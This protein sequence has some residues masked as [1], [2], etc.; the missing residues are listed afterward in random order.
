MSNRHL[1]LKNKNTN[2]NEKISLTNP[3]EKDSSDKESLYSFT[4][5]VYTDIDESMSEYIP[6]NKSE[7][8]FSEEECLQKNN[9]SQ[10][11]KNNSEENYAFDL[12]KNINRFEENFET[13]ENEVNKQDFEE[14]G[15]E[16]NI[17]V[18]GTNGSFNKKKYCPYCYNSYSKLS[19]H[20]KSAHSDEKEVYSIMNSHSSEEKKL[21]EK[22]LYKLKNLGNHIHNIKVLRE[23]RGSLVVVYRPPENA[24]VDPYK[25]LPCSSCY[26]YFMGHDIKIHREYYRLPNS[27]QQIAKLS[28][29]FLS[30]EEGK[31][32]QNSGKNLEDIEV[33]LDIGKFSFLY[34][35]HFYLKKYVSLFM[36]LFLS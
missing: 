7:N 10:K 25:Y 23:K 27:F 17:T 19:R 13:H 4:Q 22:T 6:S 33:S 32:F 26:G 11:E 34:S 21:R 5:E 12:I 31:I 30:L 3:N 8:S 14:P 2:K 15:S 20:M 18:I 1:N 36:F 35:S 29:I 16:C 24:K 28:K 9:S